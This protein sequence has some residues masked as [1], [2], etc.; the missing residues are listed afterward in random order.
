MPEVVRRGDG[1]RRTTYYEEQGSGWTRLSKE[2]FEPSRLP[3]AD[4]QQLEVVSP[5]D[6]PALKRLQ[7]EAERWEENQVAERERVA[8]EQLDLERAERESKR[9]YGA[10]R[11]AWRREFLGIVEEPPPETQE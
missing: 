10:Y 1:D 4:E 6:S 11:R 7:D 8:R 3:V 2:P 5:N 9:E